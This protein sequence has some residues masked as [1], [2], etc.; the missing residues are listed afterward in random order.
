MVGHLQSPPDSNGR[1]HR[2]GGLEIA[3]A[4]GHP[5]P[6]R[7]GQRAVPGGKIR[8]S[9]VGGDFF[10][11]AEDLRKSLENGNGKPTHISHWFFFGEN[12]QWRY[13]NIISD[14]IEI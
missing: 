9:S 4:T 10:C 12:H 3:H 1:R 11:G 2:P 6:W 14:I 7:Q 8:T 13:R 5:A